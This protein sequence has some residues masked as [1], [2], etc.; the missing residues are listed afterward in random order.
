M[1][2]NS[3]IQIKRGLLLEYLSQH[4]A[5]ARNVGV[6]DVARMQQAVELEK[7]DFA[8]LCQH[9]SDAG[10][11]KFLRR[12]G[13]FETGGGISTVWLT[14]EGFEKTRLHSMPGWKTKQAPEELQAQTDDVVKVI[15]DWLP[16]QCFKYEEA[17]IGALAEHL[18]GKGITAPEQQ[19]AS[20]TDILAAYGIA[21]EAKVTPSRSE[22]DRLVGQI[23]RQLEEFGIVIVLV[24]RPDKRDLLVEYQNRFVDDKRVI[25]V[26]K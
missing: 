23:I 5:I 16:K 24:I 3:Q 15:E 13:T 19:G 22:Y 4:G 8:A 9:L 20:L 18:E 17:Y 26:V 7:E 2:T 25:F 21:I 11:V 1:L 6:K 14:L 12:A 10:W